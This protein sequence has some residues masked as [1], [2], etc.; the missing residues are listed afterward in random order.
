MERQPVSSSNLASVGYDPQSNTLEIE[1]Q[2]GRV[3]RYH[4]VPEGLYEQ[5]MSAPSLGSFFS[6]YIRNDYPT[7][8]VG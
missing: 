3:Y 1:F 6:Q 5:L 8:R 4:G 2:N 7:E